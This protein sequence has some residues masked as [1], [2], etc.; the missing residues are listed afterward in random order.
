[1]TRFFCVTCNLLG[2]PPWPASFFC[3][4]S[5]LLVTLA[6]GF[7][8]RLR[9]GRRRFLSRF[10]RVLRGGCIVRVGTDVLHDNRNTPVRRVQRILGVSQALVRKAPHLGNL[11]APQSRLLH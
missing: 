6:G 2:W 10:F 4:S 9:A 11:I 8:F 5:L 3:S 1:M 7:G